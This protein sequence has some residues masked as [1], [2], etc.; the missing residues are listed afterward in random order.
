[1]N[2]LYATGTGVPADRSRAEIEKTLTRYGATGFIYGWE[3][4]RA[5]VAFQMNARRIKFLLPM[6]DKAEVG[7]TRTGRKRRGAAVEMAHQQEVRRRWRA[8]ALAVKAKLEVVAS[9]IVGFDEEFM[10]Y[11]VMPDG[12]TVAEHVSPS[13]AEAYQG[14]K[15]KALLPKF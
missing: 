3:G 4:L 9:G 10:P 7:K 15:M 12:K 1:M 5:L 11:I 8:L 14:G 13:I 2:R 6:P